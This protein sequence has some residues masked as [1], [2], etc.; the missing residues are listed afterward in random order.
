MKPTR[1]AKEV[2][3]SVLE[4]RL[5]RAVRPKDR[6][7][8]LVRL[9]E[10]LMGKDAAQTER[11]L[12]LFAEAER[13]AKDID[14]RRG[15]AGVLNGI[16]RCHLHL[17]NLAIALDTLTRALPIAEQTG[18]AECE[19]KILQN[20]GIVYSRQSRHDLALEIFPK[21]IE[22]AVLIGNHS[23]QASVLDGM[24]TALK[25]LGR[26]HESLECHT[27][28][29]ELLERIGHP[30]DMAIALINQSTAL[31]Y[32]GKYMEAI[33]AIEWSR[34]L[35]HSGQDRSIE[36]YCQAALGVIYSEIGDYPK[37]LASLIAS[38]KILEQIGDKLNLAGVY[39]SMAEVYLLLDNT[40]Q[41]MDFGI[42]ALAVFEEIGDKR[43]QTAMYLS[44]GEHYLKRGQKAQAMQLLNRS[45]A[46]SREI[47]SK[48]YEV[49]ILTLLAK[50]KMHIGKFATAEKLS[51]RALFIANESNEP[52]RIIAALLGLGSLFHMQSRPDQ[53][54][55]LLERAIAIAEGIHSR[56]HEQ[57]AHQLL[58]EAFEAKD[59][60]KLALVHSKLASSIK[61]E[62]LGSEKQKVITEIQI[63]AEIEKS[64]RETELLRKE[65]DRQKKE[66]ETQSQEFE[67]KTLELAEK[68]EAIRRISRRIREI[69]KSWSKITS[70]PPAGGG[71]RGMERSSLAEQLS[72]G[73]TP[74]PNSLLPPEEGAKS[75]IW[76]LLSEIE[77]EHFPENN[78]DTI[79][80]KEFEL[81]HRDIL[82]KLSQRYPSLT[83]TERKICVLLADE[84]SIKEM[85]LLLKISP[86]TV[87]WHRYGIVKKMK[88]KQRT[89]LTTVLAAI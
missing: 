85:A 25:N 10:R 39:G 82:Q 48:N 63:R 55:P 49:D 61:E 4:T 26:H 66:L 38:T 84:L 37:A 6:L 53:A 17:S 14:D 81:A 18:Y 50:Q 31:R 27:K 8:A 83:L 77:Y 89:R 51:R 5:K 68:T 47:G 40:E 71:G 60:L 32:L 36:G 87:Q 74:P 43:G 52:D 76:Q 19:I 62:I 13:L 59:D 58:A 1:P 65:R 22:L 54:L 78:E 70:L 16:G 7:W 41:T 44:L 20:M 75:A 11:A 3:L 56:R 30:Y 67:R 15:L 45:L 12:L 24:G 46:L 21:C 42:K 69:I 33:S 72:F 2:T 34:Q 79:F 9:A 88:L 23:I 73:P 57:E 86:R 64:E 35:I 29:V 28:S 80:H